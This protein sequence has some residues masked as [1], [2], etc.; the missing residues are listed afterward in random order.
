MG[1]TLHMESNTT[2]RCSLSK[3]NIETSFNS[4][5][6]TINS[7]VITVTHFP[8]ECLQRQKRR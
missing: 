1:K 5:E 2:Q 8:S 3:K 4:R 6:T 7:K